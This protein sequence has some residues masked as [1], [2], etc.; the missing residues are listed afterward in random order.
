VAVNGLPSNER[1]L[2]VEDPGDV[3]LGVVVEQPVDLEGER[4]LRCDSWIC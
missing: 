3:G 2:L 4:G 1:W